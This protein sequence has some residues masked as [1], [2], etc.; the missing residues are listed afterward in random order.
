MYTQLQRL[1]MSLMAFLSYHA[2]LKSVVSRIFP[3]QNYNEG[4][5]S[6]ISPSDQYPLP[7]R[8]MLSTILSSRAAHMESK[9]IRPGRRLHNIRVVEA[10]V[11][12]G[13]VAIASLMIPVLDVR[14]IQGR[15]NHTLAV[16]RVDTGH[17]TG[18]AADCMH[19]RLTC[20]VCLRVAS[21][22]DVGAASF[23][24]EAVASFAGRV[25]THVAL[26]LDHSL[27]SRQFLA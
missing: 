20:A 24:D 14:I 27:P 9:R 21:Q 25:G 13:F 7:H 22:V 18:E 8:D 6:P 5:K 17:G 12:T 4:K 2:G 10:T 26:K 1:Y 23:I 19:S 3:T 16:R 15:Y 11:E